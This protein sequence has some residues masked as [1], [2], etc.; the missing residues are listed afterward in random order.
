M[1]TQIWVELSR[2][3]GSDP[4]RL[5]ADAAF[6]WVS[7]ELAIVDRELATYARRYGVA[8]PGDLERLIREGK[9]EGHP[10]W[11]DCIDW[12]NLMTYREKLLSAAAAVGREVP[13]S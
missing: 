6:S 3:L 8:T 13:V 5:E 11:E 4:V 2:L 1:A 10:A 9:V 7:S 12:G